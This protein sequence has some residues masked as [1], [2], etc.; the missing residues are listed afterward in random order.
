MGKPALLLLLAASAPVAFAA[1]GSTVQKVTVEQ[2][3]ALLAAANGKTDSELA[4]ELGP[5]QLTERLST[6]KLTAMEPKLPG[7]KS[8]HQ[9]LILADSAAFLDLPSRIRGLAG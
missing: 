9:L 6:D 5:L 7:E 1:N 3:T 4:Q 2:L 8:K